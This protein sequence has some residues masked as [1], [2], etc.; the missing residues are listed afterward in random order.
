M[1]HGWQSWG[2]YP[3]RD[4]ACVSPSWIADVP[5]AVREACQRA[6]NPTLAA[7]S[8]TQERSEQKHSRSEVSPN[9]A[10]K[11]TT[12][13]AVGLG[14]S[15][16]DSGLPQDPLAIGM[17]GLRRFIDVDWQTGLLTAEAGVSLQEVIDLALPRGWFLPV[18]PGTRFVTLGGA[19][20]NDVHGKNHLSAGTFGC[21]VQ[22]LWLWRSDAGHVFC[23]PSTQPELFGATIGGLGLTGV[24]TAVQVQLAPCDS[25]WLK[26]HGQR[27][28]HL[29]EFFALDE[30]LRQL[31]DYTVAWLDCAATGK[32]LGR[33]HYLAA[34]RVPA[35]SGQPNTEPKH[36]LR[37]VPV[38]PPISLINRLSVRAFNPAY[39]YRHP[40]QWQ[41][42]VHY[43]PYF[44]PLDG[45]LHWNRLYGKHGF[46]QYQCVVPFEARQALHE[47]LHA[48]AQS[49]QGSFLSV[50]KSFGTRQSPGWLSFPQPGYTLALDF[51]QNAALAPLFARLDAI[52]QAAGGR[53]YPAKDAHM[54]AHFFRS[55][56]PR[57][58][59]LEE[60]RDPALMSAFW[61]RCALGQDA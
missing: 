53:L 23:S 37:A 25:P 3:K 6:S 45:L 50:L 22:G 39:F 28:A 58:A 60:Q 47:V 4:V 44:Y 14:R 1:Q 33:G 59:E 48:I 21:H 54:S 55:S 2:Q 9:D 20:A 52:V 35:G 32:Q 13:L 61:A 11:A 51:A 16:G 34:Q 19:V 29:D 27:F 46:Q 40:K 5:H 42:W 31:F 7:A 38:T 18:T 41:R 36:S 17:R 43:R 56:Y 24:I 15:Y 57:W 8:H 30:Q 26:E 12:T 49:G 10:A